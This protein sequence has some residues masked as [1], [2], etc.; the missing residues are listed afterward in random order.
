MLRIHAT[1]GDVLHYTSFTP[2]WKFIGGFDAAYITW[3]NY[4]RC[5]YNEQEFGELVG[6]IL[7]K[8]HKDCIPNYHAQVQA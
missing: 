7:G 3:C 8:P 6:Y 4:L 2:K 1:N 5:E